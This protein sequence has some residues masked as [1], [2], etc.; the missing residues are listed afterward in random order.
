M[1]EKK[2]KKEDTAEKPAKAEKAAKTEKA[3]KGTEKAVK[4]AKKTTKK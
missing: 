4:P 2:T 3:P 1:A